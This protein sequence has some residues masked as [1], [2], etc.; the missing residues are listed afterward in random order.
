METIIQ[1]DVEEYQ[2]GNHIPEPFGRY[3]IHTCFKGIYIGKTGTQDKYNKGNINI[4]L[5]KSNLFFSDFL[6]K[7]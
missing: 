5:I 4:N 1:T 7:P 3:I 6:N 2:H